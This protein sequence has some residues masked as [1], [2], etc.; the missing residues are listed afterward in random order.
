MWVFSSADQPLHLQS[1]QGAP[2]QSADIQHGSA[3]TIFAAGRERD[4]HWQALQGMADNLPPDLSTEFSSVLANLTGSRVPHWLNST[5]L[6]LLLKQQIL[7]CKCKL[8]TS[9]V[10]CSKVSRM[11]RTGLQII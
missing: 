5:T 10:V 1:G 7:S 3:A 6:I 2:H 4:D 9:D 11:E 8:F